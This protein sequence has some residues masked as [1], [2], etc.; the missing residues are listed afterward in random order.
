MFP[1]CRLPFKSSCYN[2]ADTLALQP[3][4]ESQETTGDEDVEK[5][6]RHCRGTQ[7]TA[8]SKVLDDARRDVHAE[9][10]TIADRFASAGRLEGEDPYIP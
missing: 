8:A 10:I 7:T 1:F 2:R 6:R 3:F 9:H 5:P 4:H